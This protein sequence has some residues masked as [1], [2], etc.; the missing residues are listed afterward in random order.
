MDNNRAA[1]VGEFDMVDKIVMDNGMQDARI[2][3]KM[4]SLCRFV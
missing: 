1:E 3:S 4:R 2:S